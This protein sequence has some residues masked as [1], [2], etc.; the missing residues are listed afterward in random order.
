MPKKK[1]SEE[2]VIETEQVSGEIEGIAYSEEEQK[3]R[4]E[5]REKAL[6]ERDNTIYGTNKLSMFTGAILR[7]RARNSGIAERV[8]TSRAELAGYIDAY[9]YGVFQDQEQGAELMADVEAMADFLGVTR[10]TL[11]RWGRGE[12][13]RDFIAPIQLAFNEIAMMKKQRA[14]NDKVNGLV[15]LSDMQNNHNYIANQKSADIHL[16]VKMNRDL[17]PIEQLNR[18]MA[19]L[20]S[21]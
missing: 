10:D 20:D 5:A 4:A 2:E 3:I 9:F 12:D 7:N 16:N 1:K 14:M 13:N 11:I 6:A 21:K 15:Y 19:L 8:Y 18:Q 17:P